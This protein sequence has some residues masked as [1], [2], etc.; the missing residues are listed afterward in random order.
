MIEFFTF[1]WGGRIA[2]TFILGLC[3]LAQTLS[4]VLNFYRQSK[5]TQRVF[6]NLLEFFILCEIII[7]SFMHGEVVNGYKNGIVV[8]IDYDNIRIATFLA[9][10]IVAIIVCYIKRTLL[11]TSIIIFAGISLPVIENIMGSIFPWLFVGA[12]IFFLVRGVKNSISNYFAIKR[13]ISALSIIN[14]LDTLHTGV[15]FSESDG[16]IV[17]SNH[18]MQR[19]MLLIT[20]KIFRNSLKF[21]EAL[22][23]DKYEAR[24]KKLGLEGQTVYL[25][26]DET[27][28]MFTKTD[29]PFHKKNY[30]HI[31]A[32]EVSEN[33]AL[34]SKLQDQEEELREKTSD[35]K[36]T[37]S[38][39]HILSKEKEIESAK[40]RAHDIIGQRLTVLLRMLQNQDNL[41]YNSLTSLSKG[42]LE[43][44]KAENM[45]TKARDELKKIQHTFEIIG[46][47]VNFQG[48]LPY[49][50]EDAQLFV[51]I[52]R[53][54]AANAVRHGFAT[55]VNVEAEERDGIYNLVVANIGYTRDEP[56]TLGSGLKAMRKKVNDQGG[57]LE[58]IHYPVF[59]LAVCLP[60]G[61]KSG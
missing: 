8:A 18:Q 14:A 29:I 13:N 24:Y 41:D 4:I 44:L 48:Q 6:E 38:N 15:L 35:L 59:T 39:L 22:I 17:L 31:S 30:V 36:S 49:D 52:I 60:G 54:G 45:E 5:T 21:Y 28:W 2:I 19:L 47:E 40:I 58:I 25:L 20:G 51:D 1:S 56:I 27:A 50:E 43:E 9:I 32:A 26:P 57:S 55:Q 7:L 53:E 33:W 42:L 34:T 23:S 16:Y 37:I 46:V 10:L 3:V 61:E 12:L 11:P